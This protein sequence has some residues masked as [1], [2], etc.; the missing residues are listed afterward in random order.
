LKVFIV[1]EGDDVGGVAI[2]IQR[3]FE[4][5]GGRGWHVRSMRGSNNYIDYP[6][7]LAWDPVRF[8]ELWEWADVIHSMEKLHNLTPHFNP[9]GKPVVLHHHGTIYRDNHAALD[10]VA[11][12]H[13][14]VQLCSTIDLTAFNPN[15]VW[16]PNPID[17]SWME[18]VR[19]Q[20]R[21][22]PLEER[23]GQVRY[24]HTPTQ[25][26]IKHT[27]EF[28]AAATSLGMK[29]EVVERVPWSQA[30]AR[31]AL[32]D[33]LLDQLA[34]G[35]GLSALEA[36][37][38]GMPVVGGVTVE[39][40]E[41][42]IMSAVGYLPYHKASPGSLKMD[43]IPIQDPDFREEVAERGRQYVNDFH[44]QPVIVKRLKRLY[45]EAVDRYEPEEAWP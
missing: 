43:L 17:I 4:R 29:L 2:A 40:L 45:R 7:D 41:S 42:R 15:V 30:L 6:K 11:N 28:I 31:K 19:A 5:Y 37:A 32:A 12:A 39:G 16:L 35:Y 24:V 21:P 9:P 27:K 33:V 44:A 10:A 18:H 22:R 26:Y 20:Y 25:R 8:R 34:Y 3:A 23:G 13:N 14:L 1:S 36:M 38:M